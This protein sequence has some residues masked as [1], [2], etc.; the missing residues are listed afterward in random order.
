MDYNELVVSQ[1]HKF[2]KVSVDH[3]KID[4]VREFVIELIKVKKNEPHHVID[5]SQE[6]KRWT[7]GVLGECAVEIFLGKEFVDYTIGDSKSYHKPDLSTIGLKC[8]VKT[9]EY[10][11][12]PVIFKRSKVSEIIVIKNSDS[13]FLICGLARSNVLNKYQSEELILSPQLRARGIKTGFYGFDKLISPN[14]MKSMF[15]KH[16]SNKETK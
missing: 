10:G 5:G 12:F 14:E 13:E 8:G 3:N 7:T 2:E 16:W 15:Q 6:H 1:L 9:V 11:K 4:K